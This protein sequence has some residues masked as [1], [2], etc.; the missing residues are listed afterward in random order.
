MA[1]DNPH[2]GDRSQNR[3]QERFLS[4]FLA[5]EPELFRYV[6]AITP[7]LEDAR[8]VVQQTAV[9]LWQKFDQYDLSLPFTPLACRFAL[10]ITKQWLARKKR[11]QS[12]L[13][14]DMAETIAKRRIELMPAMDARLRF[15]DG[16]LEKLSADQR[17][18]IEG[19]Y[20]RQLGVDGVAKESRRTV[21]AVYKAMQRIRRLLQDCIERA[22]KAE[23]LA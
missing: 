9:V 8:E 3:S 23:G 12:I 6:A 19:Y 4:L 15:L 17:R 14:D 1:A 2:P 11:W 10:N 18:I 13:A 22:Q 21:D 16:C 20:F 5:S 7:S